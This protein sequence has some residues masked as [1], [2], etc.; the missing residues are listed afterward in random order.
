MYIFIHIVCW[1]VHPVDVQC[2]LAV[3]KFF[4]R[5]F[6]I[7]ISNFIPFPYFPSK[8]SPIPSPLPLLTNPLTPA[9]LSWHPLHWGPSQDQGPLLPLMYILGLLLN[10]QFLFSFFFFFFLVWLFMY[11]LV[12]PRLH[13]FLSTIFYI[14]SGGVIGK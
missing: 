10:F 12:F 14:L 5:Y 2:H 6:F 9:S 8:Y 4:I 7:Y 13:A 3:Y 1:L 11:A